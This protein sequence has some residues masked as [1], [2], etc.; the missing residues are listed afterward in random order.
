MIDQRI[1]IHE[2]VSARRAVREDHGLSSRPN[3]GSS[4]TRRSVSTSPVQPIRPYDRR[5]IRSASSGRLA[6][7]SFTAS[8]VTRIFSCSLRGYGAVGLSTPFS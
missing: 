1:G 3:S 7:D 8:T 6:A 2:N 5:T 4:A